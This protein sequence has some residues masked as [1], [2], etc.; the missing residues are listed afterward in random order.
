MQALQP[1]ATLIY[2]PCLPP[3][4]KEVREKNKSDALALLDHALLPT[5]PLRS[6]YL[7][8]QNRKKTTIEGSSPQGNH[9]CICTKSATWKRFGVHLQKFVAIADGASGIV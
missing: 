3:V 8:R 6:L 5:F 1:P 4:G 9:S 2:A 7:F